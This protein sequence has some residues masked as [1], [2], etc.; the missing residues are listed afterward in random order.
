MGS[1]RPAGWSEADG[2]GMIVICDA[3]FIDVWLANGMT[4]RGRTWR[5]GATLQAVG[6]F[7]RIA[8]KGEFVGGNVH[9]SAGIAVEVCKTTSCF[10]NFGDTPLAAFRTDGLV[11]DLF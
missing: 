4:L 9:C 5:L 8:V 6:Y 7:C 2:V 3:D 10:W 1:G 11:E